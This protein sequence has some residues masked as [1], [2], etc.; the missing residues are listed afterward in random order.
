MSTSNGG[1]HKTDRQSR[2]SG[3][4]PVVLVRYLPGR[5]GETARVVH[6]ARLPDTGS[7]SAL[8]APGV[9]RALVGLCGVVLHPE[10]VA[11]VTPGEGVPCERCMVSHLA[12]SPLI[13][14]EPVPPNPAPALGPDTAP[15]E[16]AAIYQGW[17]WPVTLRR[18]QVWL[19]LGSAG[20][21]LM[22]PEVPARRVATLLTERRC[23]PATLTHPYSSGHRIL[24][25]GEPYPVALPWPPEVNRLT[26]ALLLPPTMTPRGPL[27][28]VC[29]PGAT[30]LR[31]C[32]EVDVLAALR[33]IGNEPP[34]PHA[35][36]AF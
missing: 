16:A 13:Q 21:A 30:A 34:P 36:T 19:A 23:P 22:L 9:P 17:G 27:T 28:W 5:A 18:D 26:T 11:Q 14:T 4:H 6:L 3:A 15:A 35:P 25:A 32:R 2:V 1:G 33:A 29:P 10:D 20:V 12:E 7:S 31:Q 24:L 8:T